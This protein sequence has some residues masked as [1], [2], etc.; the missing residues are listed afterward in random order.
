MGKPNCNAIYCMDGKAAIIKEPR[1]RLSAVAIRIPQSLRGPSFSLYFIQQGRFWETEPTYHL[2]EWVA[3]INGS[4]VGR[5]VKENGWH[6]ELL[7]AINFT[8]YSIA[9][10]QAVSAS[11]PSYDHSQLRGVIDYNSERVLKIWDEL[12][13]SG[14]DDTHVRQIRAYL[15]AWRTGTEAAELR[16][17]AKEYL[18]RSILG[19]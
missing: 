9:M 5:E 19:E 3:Y 12:D 18:G 11:D 16:A 1:G 8:V 10:A 15:A 4:I 13:A 2:D 17:F 14:A 6:Y 7:Q